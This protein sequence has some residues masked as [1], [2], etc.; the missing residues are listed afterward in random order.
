M[1]NR[2]QDRIRDF[3]RRTL[4]MGAGQV[5]LF[6][7]LAARLYHLQVI[8]GQ[9]Y[10]TLAEEN[11]INLRLLPPSRGR[12]FDRFGTLIATNQLN[13][14]VLFTAE[15]S[16]D[17]GR[18]LDRLAQLIPLSEGDRARILR[19]VKQRSGFVPI[20]VREFL[21]WDEVARIEVNSLLLPGISIE[22]GERRDYPLG[23]DAAHVLG[24]VAAVSPQDLTGDPLL[25]LPGFRIGKSGIERQFDLPMRGRAGASQLEV[26]SV[27][28][29]IRELE[30]REGQPGRELVLT[31]D[32]ELQRF[33]AKR[34]GEDSGAVVV[35]DVAKGEILALASQPAFEPNS[36]VSGIE[37]SY[38]RELTR[39]ERKP[40]N[41]KAIGGE[42]APGS[43]FKMVVAMAALEA[44]IIDPDT[45]FFC[46]GKVTL[47]DAEF[48][49]WRKGG[50]GPVSVVRGLRESCDVFFY[51]TAKRVGVDRIAEMA[52]RLGF[53]DRVGIDMPGERP[54]LIPT[55]A[56]KKATQKES[57][58]LGETLIA[59]IG[60]GY[61]TVT[62]LQLAVMAAR[63]ANGGHA[64]VPHICRDQAD[65]RTLK[66]R[67]A[68]LPPKIGFTEKNLAVVLQ[69]MAEVMQHRSGTA[70][71]SRIAEV[72]K[73]MAGKTGTSQ[74]RRITRS[75][76]ATGVIANDKLEWHLRDHAVFVGF[77][78]IAA[79][80]YAIAVLVEHGGGGSTTAAPIAKDVMLKCLERDPIAHA[81]SAA[82][83][84][85][86]S[87]P[88]TEG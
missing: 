25:E 13:Y 18:T 71:R 51:V 28:R 2:D 66:D 64:I 45:T 60:Q 82:L 86:T 79:P 38:W 85:T 57:W 56:W 43:T 48:N 11:R 87:T 19:E 74:V 53:G 16:P 40:L 36:F 46:K 9:R 23:S 39:N 12:I 1:D 77:A 31:V 84:T 63:L 67:E 29:V 33:A 17:L 26:N 35:I 42:F 10:T 32:A 59:G 4:L 61:I 37:A 83:A 54:G 65:E 44:G 49:C 50:H 88:R 30:R 78:P 47:G 41:N 14:R 52:R 5:G 73:E 69:G 58:A 62:P 72:G 6:G 3:S 68:V 55:M 15:V 34:L 8:H 27:G 22:V 7:A 80:R 70:Y 75:E 76:R 24:Y 21:S 20:T 81:P